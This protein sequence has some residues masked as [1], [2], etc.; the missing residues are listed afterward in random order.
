MPRATTKHDLVE[1][2][3]SQFAK[4]WIMIDLMSDDEQNAPFEFDNDAKLKEAHWKRDKNIRDVIIH[5]YEWHQLLLN[6]VISNQDGNPQPFLPPPYNW[7]SYGEM[8]VSFW[9][10]HQNTSLAD[11]KEMLHESHGNVMKLIDSFTNDELFTKKFFP[12]T[13]A[14]TLGSYCVSSTASH[15]DWAI[16]KIKRHIKSFQ[17]EA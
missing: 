8:N 14:S 12:W 10:K 17:R 13:G 9:E 1:S 11:S 16:K 6:W 4:L 15:Y 7:K 3:S 2:A 5:L